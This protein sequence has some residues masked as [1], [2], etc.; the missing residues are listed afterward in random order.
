MAGDWIKMRGNL[1]DD[2][3]IASLCDF[4]DAPEAMIIGGLYW[5]WSS[6]DQHSENGVMPGLSLRAIDRKTGIKGF[7]DALVSIGWL[8]DHPEGVR[9][10]RFEEHNGTSAKKRCATAKRVANHRSGD[11]EVTGDDESCNAI[12]V[13]Q[14]L[15][16]EHNGVSVALAREREEKSKPSISEQTTSTT[17][18]VRAT[19]NISPSPSPDLQ[20]RCKTLSDRLAKL[21]SARTGKSVRG[22]FGHHRLAAWVNAGITDPQFRE[23]YEIAVSERIDAHDLSPVNVGFMDIFVGKVMNPSDA[24]SSVSGVKKAWYESASGIE[25]KGKELGIPPP[26]AETGGFPAFKARVHEAVAK[27]ERIAA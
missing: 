1:W 16:E 17:N 27:L 5:L 24:P 3:R 4:T 12:S 2:P 18:T 7:G 6:A 20:D 13:T 26:T 22:G 25:A 14:E 9:I 10:T 11:T 23:A 19:A 15:H 8:A 21:E